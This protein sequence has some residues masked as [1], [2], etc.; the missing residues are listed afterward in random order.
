MVV[1]ASRDRLQLGQ[2]HHRAASAVPG[3]AALELIAAATMIGVSAVHPIA[4]LP[5]TSA[6]T[7]SR[8]FR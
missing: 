2:H 3:I 4:L 7:S 5:S 6:L 8:D 1:A